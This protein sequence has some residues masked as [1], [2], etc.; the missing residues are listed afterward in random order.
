VQALRFLDE[1]RLFRRTRLLISL[2]GSTFWNCLYMPPGS[3]V[4]Q[5]HGALKNDFDAGAAYGWCKLCSV[6]SGVRWI[7]FAVAAAMPQAALGS[8]KRLRW[9]NPLGEGCSRAYSEAV[10]EVSALLNATDAAL[11][12]EEEAPRREFARFLLDHP[13]V[14]RPAATWA[15]QVRREAR[16]CGH[17][18]A[19]RERC[20]TDS[21]EH[22]TEIGQMP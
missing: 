4:I 1:V 6:N 3:A 2:F 10:V 12:G 8:Q 22:C 9:C 18:T 14:R 20:R 11:A 16:E 21:P 19:Q 13:D 15:Q 5:I 7:P 17:R